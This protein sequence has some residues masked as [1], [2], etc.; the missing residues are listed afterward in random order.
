MT[1]ITRKE[2]ME[3]SSELFEAYYLQFALP[4][5]YE[6]VMRSV[7]IE[8]LKASKDKHLNDVKIPFNHM[9]RGGGWWWDT[10]SINTTLLKEAGECN[11]PS[12]HTCVGKAVAR[13][14]LQEH[15]DD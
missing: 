2:Y 12:T 1:L 11:S 8:A 3:N 4:A 6:Q 10:V 9:G 14:L 7:G 5:T 15:G 13:K